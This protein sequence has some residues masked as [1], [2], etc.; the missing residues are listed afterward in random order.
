MQSESRKKSR[1]NF[2]E[3]EKRMKLA[4]NK[5]TEIDLKGVENEYIPTWAD[6]AFINNRYNVLIKD[7]YQT[8]H[9]PCIRA[10]ITRLDGSI[11]PNHWSEIQKIKNEIFGEEVMAIE[12]YPKQSKL[13]DSLNAYGISIFPDGIIPEI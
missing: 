13:V 1:E 11:I 8:T 10:F 6:R 2:K 9:G 5:F 4:P 3:A 7:N 12:Y